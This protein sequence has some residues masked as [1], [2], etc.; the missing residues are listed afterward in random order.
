MR[1][2]ASFV[3][4]VVVAALLPMG[5]ASAFEDVEVRAIVRNQVSPEDYPGAGGV[6]MA[7]LDE[8]TIDGGGGMVGRTHLLARVFDPA[9][10]REQFGPFTID[11]WSENQAVVVRKASIYKSPDEAIAL[12]KESVTFVASPLVE[13][14]EPYSALRRLQV[15]FGELEPNDV[16]EIVLE[17]RKRPRGGD[18]SVQ[19]LVHSFGANDPVIEQQ[20][21]LR[22]PN[23][24]KPDITTVGP[25]VPSTRYA[26]GG[27][28][29][30][31][32]L[33][34]HL[35]PVDGGV[36]EALFGRVQ[37]NP[38]LGDSTGSIVV[39]STG[40]HYLSKYIGRQWGFILAEDGGELNRTVGDLIEGKD[41]MI[42]RAR[43]LEEFVQKEIRTLDISTAITGMRPLP[44]RDVLA[45]EAGTPID[46]SMLLLAMLRAAGID[47]QPTM[48]RTKA[49]VW[50]E[51]VACPDQLDR[52]LLHVDLGRELWL[53][54]LDSEALPPSQGFLIGL[55][56]PN[57]PDVDTDALGLFE[58][59]GR[60]AR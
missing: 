38:A 9:W 11:Y 45:S 25:R 6:W 31:E 13:G 42:E 22:A 37:R 54:P 35:A 44:C 60:E 57:A 19:W 59:P 28:F 46:K 29:R 53:D 7:R 41:D 16:V 14:I 30:R 18:F 33:N 23:A 36:E 49:G 20:L 39:S 8:I 52:V 4:S 47:A 55:I 43:V 24:L 27:F 21:R 5:T 56:D 17:K 15:D 10:G 12:P 32:W 50:D 34:G 40:W 1:F 26:D 58:F 48:V 3:C 2:F 51:K